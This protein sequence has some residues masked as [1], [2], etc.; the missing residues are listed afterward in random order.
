MTEKQIAILLKMAQNLTTT[1]NKVNSLLAEK[2][3]A[4]HDD[5]EL[6]AV[7]IVGVAMQVSQVIVLQTMEGDRE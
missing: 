6:L 5:L 1:L 2:Q 7:Q 3:G 4:S